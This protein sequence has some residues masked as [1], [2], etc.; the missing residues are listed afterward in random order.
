MK[1]SNRCNIG[2]SFCHENSKPDC[3]IADFEK[4][5]PFLKTLHAGTELA[6]GGGAIS[7]IPHDEFNKFLKFLK[8]IN[9]WKI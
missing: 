9:C 5:K 3:M 7:S 8:S 1:I 6:L 4:W 2:C